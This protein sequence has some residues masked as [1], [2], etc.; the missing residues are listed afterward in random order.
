M[1]TNR[2]RSLVAT[3]RTEARGSGTYLKDGVTFDTIKVTNVE[4][5]LERGTVKGF[6][7]RSNDDQDGWRLGLVWGCPPKVQRPKNL[8]DPRLESYT[9]RKKDWK[10]APDFI[11]RS[12]IKFN[13]AYV[14]PPTLISG[15]SRLDTTSKKEWHADTRHMNVTRGQATGICRSIG[16]GHYWMH[17][18]W[19][20][21]PKTDKPIETGVYE[22]AGD[23]ATSP[24]DKMGR[25]TS[26]FFSKP[27]A[28]TPV[29]LVW[30][31]DLL[32]GPDLRGLGCREEQG[33]AKLE[34]ALPKAPVVSAALRYVDAA[35]THNLRVN[36]EWHKVKAD[37]FD[38]KVGAWADPKD[39]ALNGCAYTYIA[40][41]G[42]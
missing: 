11:W 12:T 40:I 4:V 35:A 1:Y 28:Q 27:F 10:V 30:L 3:A 13:P 42:I 32:T 23:E 38:Y 7:G 36:A 2:G 25:Q 8:P 29:V 26:I 15:L 22:F 6:F 33:H 41:S 18:R 34:P 9:Q 17:S 39:H 20:T 16:E 5:P 37:G 24:D 14:E 31:C 19:L 21:L